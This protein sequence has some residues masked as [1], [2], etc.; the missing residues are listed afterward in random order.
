MVTN[1][2]E[3]AFGKLIGG[4][5]CLDFVNS[6]QGRIT[7]PGS[8]RPR[9]YADHVVGERLISYEALLRW[10]TLTGALTRRQAGAL[11]REASQHPARA[12]AVL[13][14]GLAVREALYRL[15]KAAI[16]HW[17]PPPEDL[18]LVN[19]ELRI[20]RA[21]ERLVASPGFGWEWDE[22]SPA[23]DRVLWPVARSAAELLTSADLALV[24][25]CPGE[26]CGWLFLDTSRSRRRQWCDM[27]DCG[28]L[29]KVRRFRQGRRSLQ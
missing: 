29:A 13:A 15:L 23:L 17:P 25:Q 27:A 1:A 11:A 22:S 4:R 2:M 7:V 6:V 16:E 10:G 20:A 28:N 19:R 26:E 14:R 3:N 8:R 12:A 24:G 18:A 9:D 21:H 5:I